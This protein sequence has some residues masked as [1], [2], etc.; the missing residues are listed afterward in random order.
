MIITASSQYLI[1]LSLKTGET[2]A[3]LHRQ[4]N[5]VPLRHI[6]LSATRVYAAYEGGAIGVWDIDKKELMFTFE[7]HTS[8]VAWLHSSED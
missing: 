1:F 4:D 6:H 5:H 7:Q 2:I 8:T 3:I